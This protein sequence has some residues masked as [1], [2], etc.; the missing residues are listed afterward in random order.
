MS[1]PGPVLPLRDLVGPLAYRY[2]WLALLILV[3]T[4]LPLLWPSLRR[5]AM[6]SRWKSWL[7]DHDRRPYVIFMAWIA[8]HNLV[9]AFM[10]PIPGTA[11]RYGA[12]NHLA[13]WWVLAFGFYFM[14]KRSPRLKTAWLGVLALLSVSNVVY[15]DQVYTAN[16][17]HMRQV[18]IQTAHYVAAHPELER[19]AAFDIG[20]L[21]SFSP[22]HVIDIGGLIDPDLKDYFHAG[23]LDRYLWERGADCLILPG[24]PGHVEEGWIDFLAV[25]GLGTSDLFDLSIM[26]TFEIDHD[27]WML[28]YLP[29]N[30]YQDSVVI[31]RLV[32]H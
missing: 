5:L 19:C 13:L 11:S 24:R 31:Y 22:T 32:P 21:R 27:R 18:R 12:I 16:Q 1:L 26:T 14:R 17:E 29:T 30:N 3:T 8:L 4:A 28:G 7:A 20:A 25:S 15:W 2:A 10:L 9:F 6:W 23:D